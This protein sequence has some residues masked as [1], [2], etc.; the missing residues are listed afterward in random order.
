MPVPHYR[1]LSCFCCRLLSA[2]PLL[3]SAGCLTP[4]FWSLIW[5]CLFVLLKKGRHVVCRPESVSCIL[6]CNCV[7]IVG[8]RGVLPAVSHAPYGN[9]L[10]PSVQFLS[11]FQRPWGKQTPS[12]PSLREKIPTCQMRG[13]FDSLISSIS[14]SRSLEQCSL[15]Q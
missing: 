1:P 9:T 3:W 2:L 5:V 8:S 13:F 6:A 14:Q 10:G 4:N 12:T 7:N 15:V 11:V